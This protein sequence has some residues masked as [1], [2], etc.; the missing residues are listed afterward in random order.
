MVHR[1]NRA[2]ALHHRTARR[3]IRIT[4][5]REMKTIAIKIAFATSLA[6]ASLTTVEPAFAQSYRHQSARDARLNVRGSAPGINQ[7]VAAVGEDNYQYWRQ[8]CC[9]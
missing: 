2:E 8:A 3:G 5:R 7:P 4:W 6:V 9:G 1:A